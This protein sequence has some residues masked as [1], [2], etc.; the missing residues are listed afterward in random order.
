MDS[1]NQ[2]LES[3]TCCIESTGVTINPNEVKNTITA[4]CVGSDYV[5]T[6]CMLAKIYFPSQAYVAGFEPSVALCNGTMF[7]ELVRIY[8]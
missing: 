1:K 7:P 4:G 8:K 6:C 3:S 5:N 2:Y